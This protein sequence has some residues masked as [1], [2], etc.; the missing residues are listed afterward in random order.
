MKY[1]L[2]GL[3]SKNQPSNPFGMKAKVNQ[4]SVSTRC[5]NFVF[6]EGDNGYFRLLSTGR[7]YLRFQERCQKR[8]LKE[9]SFCK[10]LGSERPAYTLRGPTSTYR[11][12][13]AGEFTP[14]LQHFPHDWY[15]TVP[16]VKVPG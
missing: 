7:L 1:W 5:R 4:P 6:P 15:L 9:T 16:H 8:L 10:A 14:A 2:G 13:P 3:D 11:K 12:L